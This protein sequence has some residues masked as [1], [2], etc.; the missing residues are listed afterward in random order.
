MIEQRGRCSLPWWRRVTWSVY[1]TD[2]WW[3]ET[4]RNH[5]GEWSS[6]SAF[7]WPSS[8]LLFRGPTFNSTI[9]WQSQQKYATFLKYRNTRSKQLSIFPMKRWS[10]FLC[11]S[12][13]IPFLLPSFL[14]FLF[15]FRVLSLSFVSAL[16]DVLRA[17]TRLVSPGQ[18][19][20]PSFWGQ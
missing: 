4:F 14:H 5:N 20:L 11:P 8:S 3:N 16:T 15:P 18:L 6:L 9:F 17:V 1:N 13:P 7:V 12:S 19:S 10:L 2:S